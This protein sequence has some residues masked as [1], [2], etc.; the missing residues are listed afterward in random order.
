MDKPE[1]SQ[2]IVMGGGAAILRDGVPMSAEE[3]VE[4]LNAGALFSSL[5]VP[6]TQMQGVM[7]YRFISS[8]GYEVEGLTVGITPEEWSRISEATAKEIPVIHS[9]ALVGKIVFGTGTPVAS[10]VRV[11]Q[12]QY[13]RCALPPNKPQCSCGPVRHWECNAGCKAT[14]AAAPQPKEGG[15]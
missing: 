5:Q 8:T 15:E 13:E 9:P 14:Q 11:A 10:V 12:D 7:A 1:Y 4:D 6:E 2:G 3:I